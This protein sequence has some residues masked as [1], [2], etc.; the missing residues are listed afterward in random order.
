M[1]QLPSPLAEL[2]RVCELGLSRSWWWLLLIQSWS[3]WG[4]D[5]GSSLHIL[6]LRIALRGAALLK[7]GGLLAYST[8]SFNPVEDEAVVTELL[9]RCGY[10]QHIP[11]AP[12]LRVFM[13]FCKCVHQFRTD[14]QTDRVMRS[15]PLP[16][17][18][19]V[20]RGAL[21]LV[22]TTAM[23]PTLRRRPGIF[24]WTVMDD[25]GNVYP[26]YESSQVMNIWSLLLMVR[27]YLCACKRTARDS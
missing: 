15:L 4:P 20:F 19:L 6:Q 11:C 1:P 14:R 3:T 13:G 10:L 8:C 17:H 23:L 7:T 27:V 2:F 21:E 18:P 5:Y 12:T 26:T 24:S 16:C 9:R 25:D 22:D